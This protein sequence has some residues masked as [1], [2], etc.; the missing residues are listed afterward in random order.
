ML[1]CAACGAAQTPTNAPRDLDGDRI[2]DGDQCPDEAETYNGTADDDGCPDVADPDTCIA[3][4]RQ[5]ILERVYFDEGVELRLSETPLMDVIAETLNSNTQIERLVVV[6]GSARDESAQQAEQ[7]A[8]TVRDALVQ[9]GVASHRLLA[10]GAGHQYAAGDDARDRLVW[11]VVWRIS[12]EDVADDYA[13]Q[14]VNCEENIR[15]WRNGAPRNCDCPIP[16]AP[17]S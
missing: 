4:S 9:R 8:H 3:T 2:I 10:H 15:D 12:G 11:F 13:Y 6:G 14:A 5:V 7:R 1:L 17:G 16:T